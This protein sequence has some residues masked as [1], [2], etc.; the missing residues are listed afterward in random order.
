M[1]G[2]KTRKCKKNLPLGTDLERPKT[3]SHVGESSI[4][5]NSQKRFFDE[6]RT[7][8]AP[9]ALRGNPMARGP[10]QRCREVPPGHQKHA[11]NIWKTMFLKNR[12]KTKNY[13]Q[14]REHLQNKPG[15]LVKLRILTFLKKN[16]TSRGLLWEAENELSC[17]RELNFTKS[18]KKT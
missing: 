11:K 3:C 13:L 1:L 7:R 10:S 15:M 18:K 5:E 8:G 14:K 12:Q 16:S 4:F 9:V 6:F 2:L 17:R